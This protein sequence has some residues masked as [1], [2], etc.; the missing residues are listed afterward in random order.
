MKEMNLIVNAL[1]TLT[2]GVSLQI[3]VPVTLL[4]VRV[5]NGSRGR[6]DARFVAR[7]YAARLR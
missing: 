7:K 4:K 1:A 3:E 6:Y 5:V 2:A